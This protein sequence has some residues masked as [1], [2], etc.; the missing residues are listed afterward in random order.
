[1]CGLYISWSPLS[2]EVFKRKNKKASVGSYSYKS[3]PPPCSFSHWRSNA[4]HHSAILPSSKR[5]IE[6]SF[7]ITSPPPSSGK[8]T[9]N[10]ITTL[11]PSAMQS[12]ITTRVLGITGTNKAITSLIPWNSAPQE[13]CTMNPGVHNSFRISGSLKCSIAARF[14]ISFILLVAMADFFTLRF[15]LITQVYAM[16]GE[17]TIKRCTG[18]RNTLWDNPFSSYQILCGVRICPLSLKPPL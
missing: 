2:F 3:I 8:K 18:S 13:K 10:R 9:R 14:A 11:S 7:R 12:S 16:C 15:D 6:I 1:V 17:G 4:A 5:K